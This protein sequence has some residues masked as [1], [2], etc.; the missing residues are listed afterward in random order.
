MKQETD[1]EAAST[2]G[3]NG[4]LPMYASHKMQAEPNM[5][6]VEQAA[7]RFRLMKM[8]MMILAGKKR[9]ILVMLSSSQMLEIYVLLSYLSLFSYTLKCI[10]CIVNKA[11]VSKAGSHFQHKAI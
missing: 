2:N 1:W 5:V 4:A 6:P 9:Y 8:G 11:K 10:V 7:R 3:K